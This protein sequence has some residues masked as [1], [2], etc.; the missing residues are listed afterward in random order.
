MYHPFFGLTEQPFSIAVNPRY[1]FMSDR[2]REALAHLLYGVGS[3]GGFVLL[4]GEVGTGK[5]T[6]NRCLLEQL[7]TDTDIAIVL[8]PALSATE[9]LASVCDE[10][11]ISYPSDTQSLKSLTDALHQFLLANHAKGRQTVLMIDEAQHLDFDVLEQIRL[12]TNLET[13]EKK[14]LQI[15]LTGQPELESMLA[16]PELRQLNQRITAR[17]QLTALDAH[18]TQNYIRHRLSIS[19][20]TG[21]RSLFTPSA[22]RRVFKF[23]GGIPRLINLLCDRAMMGAYGRNEPVVS[24]TIVRQAAQ[25]VFGG[26]ASP[27][28]RQPGTTRTET[29]RRVTMFFGVLSAFLA[30]LLAYN[31]LMSERVAVGESVSLAERPVTDTV[32]S[33]NASAVTEAVMP[34]WL[35]SRPAAES[36]L[37]SLWRD[38]PLISSVC[39]APG[40]A[41]LRCES[42]DS[43]T[44]DAVLELNRPVVLDLQ[45]RN[46]FAAATVLLAVREE[47]ATVFTGAMVCEVPLTA[48]ADRWQGRFRYFWESPPDWTGPVRIG[49]RGAVVAHVVGE[50]AR[51]DNLPAPP[52]TIFTEALEA[53]VRV[54]QAA[55]GLRVDGVIGVRTLQALNDKLGDG[56][57]ANR[58]LRTAI[59]RFG[60]ASCR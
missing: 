31:V 46:R 21:G 44:W 50:F 5:T 8:N 54:F 53:R 7:P 28:A 27:V 58:A 3:G 29:A 60:V 14:L 6:L 49:D 34:D 11:E 39:D 23:T 16:R 47:V 42:A 24:A 43:D 18:E 4:T 51:L 10:F 32:G 22:L 26:S 20:L 45:R 57:T 12:L 33:A 52:L 1:L 9:L 2:H 37:W 25:E 38:T 36:A 13:D 17:Y 19:G 15:I 59:E 56:L 55:V 30:G 48:V 35:V 41:G 40:T